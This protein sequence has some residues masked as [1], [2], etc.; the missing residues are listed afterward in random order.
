[1]Q[2]YQAPPKGWRL[3][4]TIP[5]YPGPARPLDGDELIAAW[6][7]GRQIALPLH[8]LPS[9]GAAPAPSA[10]RYGGFAVDAIESGE[11]LMDHEAAL[12]HT[13]ADDL[14]GYAA[15]AGSAPALPWTLTVA[16]NDTPFGTI[17]FDP[18]GAVALSGQALAVIAGDVV[19]V[20]APLAPDPSIGRVRSRS[21]GLQTDG[22]LFRGFDARRIYLEPTDCTDDGGSVHINSGNAYADAIVTDP[23][24]GRAK[25]VA[26]LWT[27]GDLATSPYGPPVGITPI[28]GSIRQACRCCA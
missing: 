4:G 26:R 1:L 23:A 19:T 9:S 2:Y 7:D 13:L 6:Q 14:A 17:T 16:L 10:Y 12:T 27:H 25:G 3:I 15:S 22:H 20:T 24:D 8:S 11:I 5:I 21:P 18:S 28:N